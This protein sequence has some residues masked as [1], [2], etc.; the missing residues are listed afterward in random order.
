MT[1]AELAYVLQ[2]GVAQAEGREPLFIGEA[3]KAMWVAALILAEPPS[4][5]PTESEEGRRPPLSE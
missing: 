3:L 2:A 4:G 5:D 1:A